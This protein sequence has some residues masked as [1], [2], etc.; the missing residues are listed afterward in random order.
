MPS[1]VYIRTKPSPWKGKHPTEEM[2]QKM[3]KPRSEQGKQ[4][5]RGIPRSEDH[6]RKMSEHRKGKHFSP[7]TEF[8]NGQSPHN[9]GKKSTKPAW[10]KGIPWSDELKAKMSQSAIGKH[11][12]EKNPMY[13]IH[14]FGEKAGGWKGGVTKINKLIRGNER[15]ITWRS[16]VWKRDNFICSKC[17]SNSK[18]HAH[19]VILLSKI[20]VDNNIKTIYDALKCD[21]VWDISN[22]ITVCEDCHTELHDH[23]MWGK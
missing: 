1:G 19:H 13:S 6:K 7:D 5:M 10:N 12:G 23:V 22:G 15:Y 4:N 8:K 21:D 9:K 18:L 20:I 14:N 3:R 2:L 17:G 11:N 16:D